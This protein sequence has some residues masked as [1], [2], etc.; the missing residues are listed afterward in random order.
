M[1]RTSYET[2]LDYNGQPDFPLVPIWHERETGHETPESTFHKISSGH[3]YAFLLESME[4]DQKT[5]RY[6]FVGADPFERLVGTKDGLNR[7]NDRGVLTLKG[8]PIDLMRGIMQEYRTPVVERL[9]RFA[10]GAVGYFSYDVVRHFESVPDNNKDE[11]HLPDLHFMIAGKMVIFDHVKQRLYV[12]V[13]MLSNITDPASAYHQ[14]MTQI[15]D[16]LDRIDQPDPVGPQTSA[17]HDHP[18]PDFDPMVQSNVPQEIFEDTVRQAKEYIAAGDIFQVVLSQ[19]FNVGIEQAPFDIYRA[20]A[21][22]NPSPYLFY[23]QMDDVHIVGASPETM[24]LVEDR[25]V[26]LRPIAGTRKRGAT[27]EE[28]EALIE[29]LL[30]DPKECAEHIMLLDLGR[31]DVGRVCEYGTVKTT[32][33]MGIEKYSH[34]SHIVSNVVGHLREGI[35]GFDV[36]EATF[37]A[38]TLSG[39]PKIRAME[40]I[41]ELE[42]T[43]R[44][45]YGGALG[46][47]GF[48]DNLDLCITIRT[49][50]IKDGRAYIQAGAGIVTDSDPETEHVECHNKAAASLRAIKKTQA[51]S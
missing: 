13:N 34:V 24:V 49:M 30:Q 7:I 39:A 3:R 23:L 37:P 32:E 25:Q 14:G 44:G 10:G 38:G 46:Y 16:L 43:R 21:R 47:I 26:T 35:D 22:L 51:T 42:T 50:V 41:D 4:G 15:D 17:T 8:N 9:P 18:I 20:L 1:Y 40:I 31:N 29:E 45:V 5:A 48:S 36:L 6:S 12:V 28:D 33:L 27:P 11:M 19:R 2:F